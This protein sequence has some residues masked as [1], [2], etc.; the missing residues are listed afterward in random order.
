[1]IGRIQVGIIVDRVVVWEENW[2]EAPGPC[3]SHASSSRGEGLNV[4]QTMGCRWRDSALPALYE[5]AY[6]FAVTAASDP[7]SIVE[8]ASC[9]A[10]RCPRDQHQE[11][12]SL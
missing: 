1:M 8:L 10:S 11:A 9:P 6:P 12:P 4:L 3:V 5:L 7:L 2:H